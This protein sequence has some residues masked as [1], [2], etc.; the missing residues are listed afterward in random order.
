MWCWAGRPRWCSAL[1]CDDYAGRVPLHCLHQSLQPS[2]PFTPPPPSPPPAPLFFLPAHPSPRRRRGAALSHR[3]PAHTAA[4]VGVY[5]CLG[6]GRG[7]LPCSTMRPTKRPG[8]A[9]AGASRHLSSGLLHTARCPPEPPARE[10]RWAG[11]TRWRGRGCQTSWR[12]CWAR[13][14]ACCS[15]GWRTARVRWQGHSSWSCCG[16]QGSTWWVGRVWEQ[17]QQ[18]GGGG[19]WGGRGGGF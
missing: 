4:G 18:C 17:T 2:S 7:A 11:Q 16:T 10:R 5:V 13:C 3:L 8:A 9:W 12:R 19:G 6:G 15:R 1:P 14:S